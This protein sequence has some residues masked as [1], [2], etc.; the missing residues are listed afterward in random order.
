MTCK[1]ECSG[2]CVFVAQQLARQ[3]AFAQHSISSLQMNT[4]LL[5]LL[6]L[7]PP[8]LP[9]PLLSPSALVLLPLTRIVPLL[10]MLLL[11]TWHV[12]TSF[13][14]R[15]RRLGVN[16]GSRP[17]S[18][19]PRRSYNCDK[20]QGWSPAGGWRWLDGARPSV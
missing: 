12:S 10:T 4:P 8:P 11:G 3:L 9:P 2:R 18:W 6:L 5:R 1:T 20:G 17:T 19:Y 7:L 14:I 15:Q 13:L 16:T